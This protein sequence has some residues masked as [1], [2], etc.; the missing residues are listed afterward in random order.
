MF[1]KVTEYNIRND[2]VRWQIST[3][4][5]IT[6]E[7]FSLALTV[8]QIFTF[9]IRDLENVGQSHNVQHSQWNHSMAIP[10]ELSVGNDNVCIF[11]QPILVKI[12][13]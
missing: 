9:Q 10:D 2:P 5:K 13:I 7:Q 1:V 8:F 11:V 3:S 12:E 6:S 4:I